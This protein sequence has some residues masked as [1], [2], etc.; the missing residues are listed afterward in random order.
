V[1]GLIVIHEA[2]DHSDDVVAGGG[3]SAEWNEVGA[4]KLARFVCSEKKMRM[5]NPVGVDLCTSTWSRGNFV[6][7][8]L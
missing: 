2:A 1:K 5:T 3:A 6:S 7:N 4:A 8:T